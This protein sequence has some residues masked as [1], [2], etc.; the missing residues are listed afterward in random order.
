MLL[1]LKQSIGESKQ[2]SNNMSLGRG[3]R[4]DSLN[5]SELGHIREGM[6]FQSWD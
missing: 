6:S 3:S 1:G 5:V 4:L 2:E